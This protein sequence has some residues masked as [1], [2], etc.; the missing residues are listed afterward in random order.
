ME[1]ERFCVKFFAQSDTD[2]NDEIF[3]NIFHEWI[4]YQKLGGVL[5][6]VADYRHVPNGPGMMLITHEINFAMDRTNGHFGLFAQQKMSQADNRQD[7]MLAL[8]R[9]TIAFGAL[10]GSDWRVKKNLSLEGGQFHL[11]SNNRLVVPNSDSAFANIL[12]D[13]EA[14]ASVIY[15]GQ[16]ISVTR[17]ENDPRERLTAVVD[18]GASMSLKELMAAVA[19]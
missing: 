15:P 19:A 8:I 14:A 17:L 3:I 9:A 12:P 16:N 13:L 4:R 10:L 5:L 7:Q 18:A 2:I 11:M 6:D 1:T